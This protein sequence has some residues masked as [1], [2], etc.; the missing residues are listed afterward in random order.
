MIMLQLFKDT[1][2]LCFSLV[3]QMSA[4]KKVNIDLKF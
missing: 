4:L 1:H 3:C 2:S